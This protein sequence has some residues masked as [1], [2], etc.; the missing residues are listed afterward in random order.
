M[1]VY[2]SFSNKGA[3]KPN[4]DKENLRLN[5]VVIMTTE[6]NLNNNAVFT[7]V[8]QQELV[9]LG[10]TSKVY[11]HL[12]HAKRGVATEDRL[13][14][15]IGYFENFRIDGTAVKADLIVFSSV[16]ENPYLPSGAIEYVFALAENEANECGFS[17]VVWLDYNDDDSVTIKSLERVDL[18]ESPALTRAMFSKIQKDYTMEE[19]ETVLEESTTGLEVSATPAPIQAPAP[20]VE[21]LVDAS[22]EKIEE[23]PKVEQFSTDRLGALETTVNEMKVLLM[24]LVTNGYAKEE[25]PKEE[26]KVVLT[27]SEPISHETAKLTKEDHRAEYHRLRKDGK[28]TEAAA[29]AKINLK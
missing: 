13:R 15:R 6:F 2:E 28:L 9:D 4:V 19:K 20:E 5:N 22:E 29:Y 14:D 10:N 16:G 23:A 8:N 26:K 24:Q 18:V 12:G 25:E 21:E 11:C 1:P 17:M 7:F 27:F 3:E